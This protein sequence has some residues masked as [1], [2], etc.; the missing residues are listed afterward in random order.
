[1]GRGRTLCAPRAP[2]VPSNVEGLPLAA[3]LVGRFL[4][5]AASQERRPPYEDRNAT[6]YAS[7]N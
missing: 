7:G 1:M 5:I 4:P 2:H 6:R 3:R